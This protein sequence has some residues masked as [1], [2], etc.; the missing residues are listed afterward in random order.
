MVVSP[1][2]FF[3]IIASISVLSIALFALSIS[4]Y[5]VLKKMM[6]REQRYDEL[7][8]GMDEKA[9]DLLE[10]AR[11]KSAD[12]IEEATQK[13]QQIITGGQSLN[14]NSRKMLD[15]ALET[16][17]KQQ[18]SY[19]EKASQDFLQ[20]YKKELNFLRENTVEIAKNASKA[21]EADTLKEVD[22]YE[23]VIQQ[24][25]IGSQKIVEKKIE[26]EYAKTQ[27]EVSAYKVEMLKKIDE[28]IYAILESVSK[29]AIGKSIPLA[30]H[31][32][33]IID[34]LE[35]AKNSI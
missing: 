30:Q 25:T 34:A 33:L 24:E 29:E 26:E 22:D 1:L 15:E 5:H 27:K 17:I 21:I 13:A 7:F 32:Q 4:Y 23:K 19:F 6:L 18:T 3:V 31:E 20:E 10:N 11:K 2:F 12:I 35:K 8:K 28:E 16:L 9:V 14:N